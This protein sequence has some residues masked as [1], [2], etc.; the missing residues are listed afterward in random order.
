MRQWITYT[1]DGVRLFV[2]RRQDGWSVICGE[3]DG[4]E[5]ELL[6]VALI[7]AIRKEAEVGGHSMRHEYARWTR[8]LADRLQRED[9]SR[10]PPHHSTDI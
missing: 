5:H 6:D 3:S 1:P 7:E 9:R 10:Y 4:V 8:E 2:S